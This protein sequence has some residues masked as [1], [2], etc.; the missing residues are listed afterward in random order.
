MQRVRGPARVENRVGV[1]AGR[2]P[3]GPTQGVEGRSV[4]NPPAALILAARREGY[5]FREPNRQHL[6]E[7][8]GGLL[9]AEDVESV[10]GARRP[11][12]RIGCRDFV[13]V[14]DDDATCRHRR[15]T[16]LHPSDRKST[17]LNSSHQIISYAVFCLKKKKY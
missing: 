3:H 14:V 16:D 10:G 13:R 15:E 9:R 5:A 11:A 1:G 6:T 17:R 4:L 8:E 7:N 2:P 12:Y